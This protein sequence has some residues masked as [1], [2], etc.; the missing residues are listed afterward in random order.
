MKHGFVYIITN[1]RMTV[2]YT[3]STQDLKT[4]VNH[5]KHR[6]VPGFSKKYN[7]HRL[8]YFEKLPDIEAAEARERQIKGYGRAKKEAL[9]LEKNPSWRDMYFELP[10]A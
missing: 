9:I 3:G 8:I 2:L 10:Q 1:D 7:V 4:R 6:Y 5:H